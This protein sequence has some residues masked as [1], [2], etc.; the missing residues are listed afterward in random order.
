MAD[1]TGLYASAILHEV[2]LDAAGA[3]VSSRPLK[4]RQ[5]SGDRD[6]ASA[7]IV[8]LSSFENDIHQLQ[9]RE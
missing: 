1:T 3:P 8:H 4:V 6:K 9:L 7:G 5:M 2:A